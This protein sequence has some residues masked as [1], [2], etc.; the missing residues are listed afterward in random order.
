[1]PR[2][3]RS[4]TP[5][6]PS[7]GTLAFH[8]IADADFIDQ[9]TLSDVWRGISKDS[10]IVDI[11]RV[12]QAESTA[13]YVTKYASKPLNT[14]FATSPALLDQA[15]TA[16]KGRRLCLCFGSWYGTSLTDAEDDTLLEDQDQEDW[17]MFADIETLI[18]RAMHGD[19]DATYVLVSAG[20]EVRLRQMF[21]SSS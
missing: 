12:R 5:T 18:N 14:S 1:M 6:R 13:R 17:K 11:R 2:S 9:G 10:F 21:E 3:W 20:G 19:R 16:L 4:N 7:G 15:L 8:V